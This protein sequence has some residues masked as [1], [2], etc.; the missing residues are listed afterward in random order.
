MWHLSKEASLEEGAPVGGSRG[1]PGRAAATA[2][3]PA[4]AAACGGAAGYVK[5]RG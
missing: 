1:A 5:M 3:E 2:A 4:A